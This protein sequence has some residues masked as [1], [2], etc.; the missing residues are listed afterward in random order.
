MRDLAQYSDYK[1]FKRTGLSQS[2]INEDAGNAVAYATFDKGYATNPYT[3]KSRVA[4]SRHSSRRSQRGMSMGNAY[5]QL[6]NSD[7]KTID[8][9][10]F[11][12]ELSVKHSRGPNSVSSRRSGIEIHS[13]A[14]NAPIIDR[15]TSQVK[16]RPSSSN[17][18][19][20]SMSNTTSSYYKSKLIEAI[21][22][23]YHNKKQKTWR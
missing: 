4:S 6:P 20:A 11:N 5:Q 3:G 22:Y 19:N 18:L 23:N 15:K 1:N 13:K 17:K 12:E 21:A 10:R 16:E 9:K 7:S 8:I 14:L 2:N